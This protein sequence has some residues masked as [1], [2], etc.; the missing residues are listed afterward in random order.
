MRTIRLAMLG[1]LL[2]LGAHAAEE[3]AG[4]SQRGRELFRSESCVQCHS[5][6]GQ[7]GKVAPDLGRRVDRDF[8]P[9]VLASTMWNHAP[10]MWSAMRSQG[11]EKR[12]LSEQAAADLFA[13]FYSTRF[14]DKPGDAGRGKQLF[15]AHHCAEC[16]GIATPK[17][18]GAKPV[19][20]WTA[21]GHPII[22]VQA[23]W[24][25]AANMRAAFAQKKIPWQQLTSQELTD[26]LVYLRN[27]PETRNL[28]AGFEYPP[29]QGGDALFQS[30]GCIK[31][32]V[33]RLALENRLRDLTLTDIAVDM[34]N[35]APRM[36]PAP[37]A[38][39]QDEMRKIVSYLWVRQ[40]FRG[41]GSATR[42]KRV[43]T[44]KNCAT[45]HNNPSSGAPN[46]AAKKGSF[47]TI[48]MVAALWDHGPGMLAQMQAKNLP[49]PQFDARQMSDLIAYLNA[50][51]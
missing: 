1:S 4:D 36:K 13:Y 44:E 30:K 22:L 40:F 42:G 34:W 19:A 12:Q 46:L 3:V 23:M 31:C 2:I 5:I 16:H 38:L 17:E 32:H 27:L 10:T 25:H 7:G 47:S 28:P 14:F 20:Q 26:I 21:L 51:Q 24:N 9:A 29:A 37:P 48:S 6:N 33:G 50:L 11:V 18:S 41:G 39:E 8:T 35:H 15:S 43:F 49:W 45:C